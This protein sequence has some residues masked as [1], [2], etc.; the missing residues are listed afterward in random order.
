MI[1]EDDSKVGE[2]KTMEII[3][4]GLMDRRRWPRRE[5]EEEGEKRI[6]WPLVRLG[7]LRAQQLV[8]SQAWMDNNNNRET[9]RGGRMRLHRRMEGSYHG[10]S[11]WGWAEGMH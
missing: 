5:R 9:R 4:E 2:E 1:V 7:F 10:I 6:A 8:G 11:A 3:V